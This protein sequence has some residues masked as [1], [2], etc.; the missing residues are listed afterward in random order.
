MLVYVPV[1]LYAVSCTVE[2]KLQIELSLDMDNMVVD[3]V[4]SNFSKPSLVIATTHNNI[5]FVLG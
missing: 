3:K 5:F 2:M 4:V 1:L